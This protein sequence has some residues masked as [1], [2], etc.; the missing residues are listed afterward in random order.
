[1]IAE[2]G[3]ERLGRQPES[4]FSFCAECAQMSC[5]GAC[6]TFACLEHHVLYHRRGNHRMRN[7]YCVYDLKSEAIAGGIILE[8]LDAPAIRAFHDAL[9]P[10][11]ATVLSSH[12]A[13]FQLICLGSVDDSGQIVVNPSWLTP[14]ATG[15]QW[16]AA[17]YLN[18]EVSK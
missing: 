2:G 4:L 14:V 17:N 18:E 3:P 12:P 6:G 8:R 16:A 1:M 7:M 15:A 13:D 10:K 9:D 5:K 11:H